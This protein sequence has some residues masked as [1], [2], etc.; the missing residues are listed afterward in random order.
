M[1]EIA[2]WQ[3]QYPVLVSKRTIASRQLFID[4]L[5]SVAAIM[6]VT[7]GV[8]CCI[9]GNRVLLHMLALYC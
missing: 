7:Q 5:Q 1:Y 2:H 6:S 8:V 4:H 9:L 3:M